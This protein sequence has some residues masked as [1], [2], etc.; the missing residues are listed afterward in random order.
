M[1]DSDDAIDFLAFDGDPLEDH[2]RKSA[3]CQLVGMGVTIYRGDKPTTGQCP[4]CSL[5]KPDVATRRLNTMYHNDESNWLHSCGD[6]YA[7]AVDHYRELWD[8]YYN[9][10]GV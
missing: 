9:G 1:S 5:E 10:L 3:E 2:R 4:V 7:D 8:E 6:C